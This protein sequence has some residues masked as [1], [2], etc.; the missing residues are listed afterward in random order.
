MLVSDKVAGE[1]CGGAKPIIGC[2][3]DGPRPLSPEPQDRSSDCCWKAFPHPAPKF[4]SI[5][6]ALKKPLSKHALQRWF[7]FPSSKLV[8]LLT[9]WFYIMRGFQNNSA[10]LI[11]F[12]FFLSFS[13]LRKTREGTIIF[14]PFLSSVIWRFHVIFY[15]A[16]FLALQIFYKSCKQKTCSHSFMT[17]FPILFSFSYLWSVVFEISLN[18][19]LSLSLSLTLYLSA[20]IWWKQILGFTTFRNSGHYSKHSLKTQKMWIQ[21]KGRLS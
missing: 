15:L 18:Q 5:F 2:W 21:S 13:V 10:F 14:V 9:N 6:I 19:L 20:R 8:I 7:F 16:L 11:Q 4:F 17:F 12:F 3:K 1:E